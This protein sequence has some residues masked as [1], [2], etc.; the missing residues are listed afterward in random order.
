MSPQP[1]KFESNAEKQKAF[2]ER[3]KKSLLQK[4][5]DALKSE[6]VQE[7]EECLIP[8]AEIQQETNALQQ[9]PIGTAIFLPPRENAPSTKSTIGSTEQ[10]L[11]SKKSGGR[12]ELCGI[13]LSPRE[14]SRCGNCQQ[15]QSKEEMLYA[16]D[17][18]RRLIRSS[19]STVNTELERIAQ[20][21]M[22]KWRLEHNIQRSEP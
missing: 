6:P 14:G 5:K 22:K 4:L 10:A 17:L 12:C 1:K 16:R 7:N 11:K 3:K 21:A 13:L 15:F 19:N 8:N 9:K 2:R 20:E 18:R